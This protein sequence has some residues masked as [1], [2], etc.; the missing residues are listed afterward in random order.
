MF[1][2]NIW[3]KVELTEFDLSGA[4]RSAV[5]SQNVGGDI[6]CCFITSE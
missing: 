1:L 4:R 5:I 2:L 6:D 3:K